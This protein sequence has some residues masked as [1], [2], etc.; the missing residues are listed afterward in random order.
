MIT[1]IV[2]AESKAAGTTFFPEISH[3]ASEN[4]YREN[5]IK[6]KEAGIKFPTNAGIK[7]THEVGTNK[8]ETAPYKNTPAIP[9]RKRNEENFMNVS[10]LSIS[11]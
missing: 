4:S 6:N 9:I 8:E 5:P 1:R 11:Y 3:N 10:L 7:P 2:I